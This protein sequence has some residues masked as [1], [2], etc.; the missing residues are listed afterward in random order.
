MYVAVVAEVVLVNIKYQKVPVPLH[1]SRIT[2]ATAGDNDGN[3]APPI[4]NVCQ[5]CA[6]FASSASTQ[7]HGV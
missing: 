4:P 6:R 7:P 5:S 1:L 2:T 3:D